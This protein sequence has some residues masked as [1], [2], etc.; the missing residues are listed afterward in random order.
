[1]FNAVDS[2]NGVKY[3]KNVCV[4]K[5]QSGIKRGVVY[6]VQIEQY[7]INIIVLASVGPV[8]KEMDLHVNKLSESGPGKENQI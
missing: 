7:L 8:S 3:R 5:K 2:K 4:S 1:V 6:P